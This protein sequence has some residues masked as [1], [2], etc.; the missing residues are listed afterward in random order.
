MGARKWAQAILPGTPTECVWFVFH[1]TCSR[2]Y[3]ALCRDDGLD[4]GSGVTC[5]H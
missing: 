5:E 2:R 3:K 4:H 1:P